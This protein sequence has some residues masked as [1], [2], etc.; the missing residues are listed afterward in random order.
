MRT[1]AHTLT[2]EEGAP[3]V[4]CLPLACPNKGFMCVPLVNPLY[5]SPETLFFSH[6]PSCRLQTCHLT[7]VILTIW[8]F[9][10]IHLVSPAV[11]CLRVQTVQTLQSPLTDALDSTLHPI[12]DN[13][14]HLTTNYFDRLNN[15]S[16][17]WLVAMQTKLLNPVWLAFHSGCC[18]L[19]FYC[20]DF[21]INLL[22]GVFC[23]INLLFYWCGRV[24]TGLDLWQ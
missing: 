13:W 18:R 23:K 5:C 19:L 14:V 24:Q 2:R 3:F 9:P 8:C 22:C 11:Y 7:L 10:S 4:I 20:R 15:S 21:S 1:R 6:L 16:W 12:T 17:T